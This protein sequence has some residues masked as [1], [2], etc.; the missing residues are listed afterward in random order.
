MTERCMAALQD[1]NNFKKI[2][3]DWYEK[4]KLGKR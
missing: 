2:I 3:P 4:Y 1:Y